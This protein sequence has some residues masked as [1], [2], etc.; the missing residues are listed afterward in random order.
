MVSAP[1]GFGLAGVFAG[2]AVASVLTVRRGWSPTLR[3]SALIGALVRIAV[4][5]LAPTLTPTDVLVWFREAGRLVLHG[6][7]PLTALPR[8][9]WNFTPLMPYVFGAEQHTG[10]AWVYAGKI[11]P[12][13]ADLVVISLVAALTRDPR[14]RRRNA[15]LYALSPLAI[16]VAAVHGQVEPVAIALGLGALLLARRGRP[17]TAGL[18]LGAAV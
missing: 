14:W 9:E 5:V 13:A 18:L 1:A 17:G 8:F 15:L 3:A 12:V 10:L 11:V 7:D 2:C 6:R 16:A 4:V